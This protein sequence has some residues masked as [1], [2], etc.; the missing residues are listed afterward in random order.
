VGSCS[1]ERSFGGGARPSFSCSTRSLHSLLKNGI[2]IAIRFEMN[3]RRVIILSALCTALLSLL[4][5]VWLYPRFK[6]IEKRGP[7]PATVAAIVPGDLNA[8]AVSIESTFNNWSDFD[9]PD[10]IGNY[11]DKFPYGSHW[12]RFFLFRRGDAQHPLFPTDEEIHLDRGMDSFVERYTRVPSDLRMR[13]LYLYEPSGDYYWDSE[14]FYRNQ[15][16]KF[17]CSFLIHLEP[18]GES[19]TKVEVFEY[20]PEIWVGEYLGLSAHAV[21]P[22]M[23]YDIRFVEATTTDRNE[24]LK[25]IQ[26]A[27]NATSDERPR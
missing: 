19:S 18:A 27:K 20:Q 22:G 26:A 3:L 6:K 10:R 16:A 9:R 23:L 15:P 25:M 8:T 24:V 4:V 11:K 13:D 17:R 2:I 7:A 12:S 5:A 21:L 14:Y 1:R